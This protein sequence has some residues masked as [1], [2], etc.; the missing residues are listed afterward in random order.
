M[1]GCFRIEEN[2]V[3]LSALQRDLVTLVLKT[4]G[5]LFSGCSHGSSRCYEPKSHRSSIHIAT[6][7]CMATHLA[8]VGPDGWP[9]ARRRRVHAAQRSKSAAG[10]TH[11]PCKA[12][13]LAARPLWIEGL[14]GMPL[15]SP[16]EKC[17]NPRCYHHRHCKY[18]EGHYTQGKQISKST[19][20]GQ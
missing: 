16:P 9:A 8:T 15:S 11:A 3:N 17:A 1:L 4:D 19:G 7:R 12:W 18:C 13:R 20:K 6:E 14:G 10:R 2:L 5:E